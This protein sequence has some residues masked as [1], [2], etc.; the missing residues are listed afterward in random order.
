[1]KCS[2]V[3]GALIGP[4][5]T[6]REYASSL[7]KSPTIDDKRFLLS[8]VSGSWSVVEENPSPAHPF[9]HDLY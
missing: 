4:D 2:Q 5:D 9:S 3:A 6:P 8:V 7:A 1:M